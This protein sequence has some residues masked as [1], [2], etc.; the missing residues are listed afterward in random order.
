MNDALHTVR[1]KNNYFEKKIR[2]GSH[3][4]GGEIFSDLS[5]QYL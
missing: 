2:F 5:N 4:K 1:D 3:K